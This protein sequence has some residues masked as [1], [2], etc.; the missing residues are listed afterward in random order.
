MDFSLSCPPLIPSAHANPQ[1]KA[2][3][4]NYE[5]PECCPHPFPSGEVLI[6]WR[7]VS[8]HILKLFPIDTDNLVTTSSK[9][10]LVSSPL[11]VMAHLIS[12]TLW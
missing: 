9:S 8:L 2:E 12:K 5:I 4:A 11:S 7:F 1:K 10:T 3:D 6:L